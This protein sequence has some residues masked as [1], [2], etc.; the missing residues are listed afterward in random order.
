M[1]NLRG[2]ARD[3]LRCRSSAAIERIA[4]R[5]MCCSVGGNISLDSVDNQR[6]QLANLRPYI[7]NP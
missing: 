1:K 5:R 6:T 7:I 4:A 2:T 3:R